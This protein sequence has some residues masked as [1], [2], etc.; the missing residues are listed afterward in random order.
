MIERSLVLMKTDAVQR[1]VVGEILHRFERASL[2]MVAV[3]LTQADERLAD[4][5]YPATDKW[6]QSVGDKTLLDFEKA[7]MDPMEYYGTTDPIGIGKVVKKWNEEYLKAGPIL[8]VVFEGVNAV[9]RIR[10]LVGHTFPV[11]AVP[12]TIRSD[13]SLESVHSGNRRKRSVYNLIHASG[14][15]SEAEVEIKLWF[16]KSEIMSY[17]RVHEDLY[18]Y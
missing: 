8:A 14:T 18:N 15:V 4:K 10:S 9:E 7:N 13:F 5:H 12:G 6:Y 16:K 1:G 17:K 11:N 3:K 2:K